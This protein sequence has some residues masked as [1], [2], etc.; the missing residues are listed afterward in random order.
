MGQGEGDDEVF[1]L[2]STENPAATHQ[3]HMHQDEAR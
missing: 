1:T 2:E 3:R